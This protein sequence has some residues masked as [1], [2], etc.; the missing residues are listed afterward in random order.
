MAGMRSPTD[1]RGLP[2]LLAAV[3][4]W[5]STFVL[6]KGL[7][8][9]IG[10]LTL[11]VARFLV[12]LMVLVPLA[13]RHGFTLRLALTRRYLLFGASGV[14]AYFGLQNLALVFTTAGSA[15]LISALIPATTALWAAVVLKERPTRVQLA[16]IALSVVGVSLVVRSGLALGDV[17]ALIGNLMMLGTTWVWAV[18]TVEGRRLAADTPALVLS[19]GSIAAGTL[20]LLPM[21][22]VELAVHGPPELRWSGV[23]GIVY[24]GLAASA[25]TFWLWNWALAHVRAPAAAAAVN[26]VPVVGLAFAVLAGEAVTSL[27]LLGGGIAVVAVALA[28]G[29]SAPEP[30][31]QPAPADDF[32]REDAVP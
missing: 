10:P 26:L 20:L 12:A 9:Q 23:A 30:T 11:A 28:Q 32:P 2:A 7:L 27:Q 4:I 13:H 1:R 15:A 22:F 3:L 21:A 17:S 5:G 31:A 6:T 14:T 25:L 24:L 8:D 16:G 29:P 18:Y 19:T